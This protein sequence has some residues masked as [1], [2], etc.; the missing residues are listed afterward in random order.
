MMAASVSTEDLYKCYEILYNASGSVAKYQNEYESIL[1]GI[2]GS[3]S[4]KRLVPSIL[5]KF[6]HSFPS[7][8]AKT[9]HCLCDLLE[10][11]DASVSARF[12]RNVSIFH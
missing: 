7:L 11:A 6:I 1:D 4:L 2:R 5:V 9:L 8:H 12:P 10:D 3:T